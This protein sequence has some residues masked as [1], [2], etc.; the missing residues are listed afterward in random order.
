MPTKNDEGNAITHSSGLK[1]RNKRTRN[2]T[3][4]DLN[5]RYVQ[6]FVCEDTRRRTLH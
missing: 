1:V 3:K 6:G 4:R 5:Y 2:S